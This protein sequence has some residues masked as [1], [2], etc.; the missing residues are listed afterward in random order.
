MDAER[1]SK[2]SKGNV[3]QSLLEGTG[4]GGM[5]SAGYF[6][7]NSLI[8]RLH[9]GERVDYA[10]Q[11]LTKGITSGNGDSDDTISPHSSYRTV[12][13]VTD[14]RLLYVVGQRNGDKTFSVRLEDIRDVEI[15]H[16]VLKDRIIVQTDD[17]TYDMYTQK[18]GSLDEA[19][20][21]I[22]GSQKRGQKNRMNHLAMTKSSEQTK[23]LQIT[24][25]IS[26]PT[27]PNNLLMY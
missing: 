16:G 17:E 5:L 27:D 1:I 22:T 26:L 9:D 2:Q 4:S 13:L 21:H 7:D 19:S 23:K 18:G 3:D 10:L 6:N 11:N 20:K 14:E 15:S 8:D 24:T 25:Q 12:L